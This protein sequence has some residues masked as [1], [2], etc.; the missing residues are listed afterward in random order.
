MR[1]PSPQPSKGLAP[2]VAGGGAEGEKLFPSPEHTCRAPP[3]G[4]LP[5]SGRTHSWLNCSSQF[6][7]LL[8]ASGA[9]GLAP[10]TP[11]RMV[12]HSGILPASWYLEISQGGSSYTKEIGKCYKPGLFWEPGEGKVFTSTS[13]LLAQPNISFYPRTMIRNSQFCLVYFSP[14]CFKRGS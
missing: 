14:L 9:L 13:L 2:L 10:P 12:Q 8:S 1:P 5:E 3:R 6:E 7:W 11:E 4:G